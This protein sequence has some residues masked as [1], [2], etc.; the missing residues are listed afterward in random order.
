MERAGEQAEVLADMLHELG[1]GVSQV[2][3]SWGAVY[4]A[5]F[6]V[7]NSG[8]LGQKH[9]DT[10]ARV[11]VYSGGSVMVSSASQRFL[12]KLRALFDVFESYRVEPGLSYDYEVGGQAFSA[13]LR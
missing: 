12:L 13:E 3:R 1:F 2:R 10:T 6:G 5:S 7:I 9:P 4:A 11:L 8:S